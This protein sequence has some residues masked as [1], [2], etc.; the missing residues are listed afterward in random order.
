MASCSNT[1]EANAYEN[2]A[3]PEQPK[4]I[5]VSPVVLHPKSR[6]SISLKSSNPLQAPSIRVNYLKE[7]EDAATLIE[8]V[9][10]VQKIANFT[11]LQEKYGLELRKDDYGNCEDLH[12]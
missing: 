11:M 6:G 5:N 3:N 12:E 2:P 7:P 1:G 8:G 9:R 10:I 4:L